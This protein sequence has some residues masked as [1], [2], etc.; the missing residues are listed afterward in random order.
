MPNHNA[1]NCSLIGEWITSCSDKIIQYLRF[2]SRKLENEREQG[3]E[4]KRCYF[5]CEHFT[6]LFTL[7][8]KFYKIK[9]THTNIDLIKG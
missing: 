9:Y 8:F 5:K 7:V 4:S 6:I 3:R 1:E 2:S